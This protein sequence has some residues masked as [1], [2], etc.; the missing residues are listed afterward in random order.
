MNS[1]N[2]IAAVRNAARNSPWIV[3]AV[4]L[5][6]ILIAVATV[7]YTTRRDEVADL[8]PSRV[9]PTAPRVVEEIV[10]PP[11]I[12]PD[13]NAIPRNDDRELVSVD[14]YHPLDLAPPTAEE[15]RGEDT[16]HEDAPPGIELASTA[17]GAAANGPGYRKGS[18][19]AI[20][21]DRP[22]VSGKGE[23][24]GRIPDGGE[25]TERSVLA[26]LRWLARHQG[27]DGSWSARG[28]AASCDEDHRCDTAKSARAEHY[29]EG[30][31][32]LAL[33]AFLGAGFSHD[34]KL[35]FH[36]PAR[37]NQKVV[38]GPVV[39]RGLQWLVDHQNPD[40]SFGKDRPFQY[41]QALAA[42]ALAEAFGLTQARYWRDPAQRA[43]TYLAK[44]QR[45][46]PTGKGLWGWRY[47]ARQD[48]E[49]MHLGDSL[50]ERFAKELY[51]AD[52]S[53]TAWAVMALKSA[54]L[55]G[56]DVPD[57]HLE[58]ALAF[59]QWVSTPDGLAGY[60]DPKGAGLKVSGPDDHFVYHAST[61]SALSMCIR[62]FAAH[63]VDDPYLEAA[64][65]RLLQDLPAVSSDRLSVD[66][67]SWYYGSLALYQFDGP[68]APRPKGKYWAPWN[69]AMQKA[70][71]DLQEQ[72]RGCGEG[73]WLVPD[74]WCHSGGP[75]YATALN[76]LTLEVYYRYQ[77]AFSAA[78]KRPAGEV[79]PA[80]AGR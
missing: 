77:N 23:V 7:F 63:D 11:F 72:G 12:P 60:L 45:P 6:L 46:S 9:V 32:S 56:L 17:I 13:R 79:Q 55:A 52:T 38:V 41:N 68:D 80:H 49:R 4:A 76:V 51:D 73:G 58:G 15:P 57:E 3:M 75:I 62:T 61:M 64:A 48:V 78:R 29:D 33:L 70:V 21:G 65:K 31:T 19:S 16:G 53:V 54:K 44:A 24:D 10:I 37:G 74:R 14:E 30:L 47:L 59:A 25:K 69:K 27:Q 36:D 67:Y 1:W 22:Y 43:A 50:D 42:M 35:Y 40:G 8:D 66:Y 71:L 20:T 5:H 18:P 26:G 39:K 34:S 28:L 2:P